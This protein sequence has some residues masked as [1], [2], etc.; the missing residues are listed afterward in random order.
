MSRD[1]IRALV[2]ASVNIPV[3]ELAS[4]MIRCNCSESEIT[5]MRFYSQSIERSHAD[6]G[7]YL[8][9]RSRPENGQ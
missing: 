8:L 7:E 2:H 5:F 3:N 9:N 6:K 1:E 4:K